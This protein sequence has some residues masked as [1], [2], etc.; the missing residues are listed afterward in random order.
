MSIRVLRRGLRAETT[1]RCHIVVQWRP[2]K[3]Q[4]RKSRAECITIEGPGC[5]DPAKVASLIGKLIAQAGANGQDIDSLIQET[6]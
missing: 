1:D 4:R 2:L 5:D 6:A 3:G